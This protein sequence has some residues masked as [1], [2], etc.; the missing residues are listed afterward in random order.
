MKR[1]PKVIAGVIA[2][3]LVIALLFSIVPYLFFGS[4]AY[5]A[6]QENIKKLE[7]QLT[8]IAAQKKKIEQELSKITKD[9]KSLISQKAK[10]DEQIELAAHEIEVSE[11][12]ISALSDNI[13]EREAEIERLEGE[14]QAQHELLKKR[15]RAMYE[16]GTATY[17]GILLE[18]DSFS[19]FLT[20]FEVV[21]QIA[22]YDKELI[23]GICALKEQVTCNKEEIEKN[24]SAE[25]TQRATL[26]AQK[27]DL[28]KKSEQASKMIRDLENNEEEFKENYAEIEKEEEKVQKEIKE[29]IAELAKKNVYVGGTFTWPLPGYYTITSEFGMRKHPI[30]K[31]MKLHTGVDIG[32]P[33]GTTIV[34]ANSGT[35]VTSSYS[36]AY[37]NYVAIDHGGGVATLYAHMSKRLVSKGDTVKKGQKIGLVGSTGYSTGNHLHFEIIKNGEYIDPMT[38]FKKG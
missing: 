13:A 34:A 2:A 38:E 5:Q 33:K 6:S 8:D 14:Q 25:E 16:S 29:M 26:E 37:G 22:E 30:L 12:L 32:A 15:L 9:R 36:T 21:S 11:E 27:T 24:R 17:L 1:W 7:K 18:S 31:V 28:I 35:V 3:L 4:Y 20:R 19:S 23:K 10:L